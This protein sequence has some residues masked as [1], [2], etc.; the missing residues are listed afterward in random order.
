MK[1]VVNESSKIKMYCLIFQILLY[2]HFNEIFI[3]HLLNI[4][5]FIFISL[6]LFIYYLLSALTI[7]QIHKCNNTTMYKISMAA[8]LSFYCSF[9]WCYCYCNGYNLINVNTHAIIKYLNYNFLI[10]QIQI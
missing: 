3:Y 1:M 7:S 9:S 10:Q 2:W 6:L 8:S 4:L 5:K